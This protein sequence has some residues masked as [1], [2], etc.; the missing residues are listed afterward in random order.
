MLIIIAGATLFLTGIIVFLL[1]QF[2]SQF[3]YTWLVSV[4]ASFIAWALVLASRWLPSKSI[5]LE[6]WLP[7]SLL[8][9]TI[10]FVVD[11]ISWPYAFSLATILFAVLL[12][13]AVENLPREGSKSW[14]G[15][16]LVTGIGLLVML[17]GNPLTLVL[18]WAA[19][20]VVEFTVIVRSITGKEVLNRTILSFTSRLLGV[21]LATWSMLVS[22]TGP[23]VLTFNDITPE[24]GVFMLLASGLRLGVIPL[25]LPYVKE[26][27]L[28][29]GF[30][31][32]LRLLAPASSLVVLARLPA[33]VVQP[34]VA[35]YLL[36]LTA[37]ASLYGSFMWFTSQN[38]LDARPYWLVALAGMSVAS[39]IRGRP[40]ASVAW[41]LALILV[42]GLVF[43]YYSRRKEISMVVPALA[44]LGLSGLPY[45]PSASGWEGLIVLPF[46]ALDVIYLITHAL[47]LMGTIRLLTKP[48]IS[49]KGTERWLQIVYLLGLLVLVVSH[50]MIGIF[51]WKG[52]L[53]P[54]TWWAPTLSIVITGGFFIFFLQKKTS[55]KLQEAL[56][57]LSW[58]NYIWSLIGQRFATFFSLE[59]FY[60]FM[61]RV[62]IILQ[63]IQVNFTALLE[64]QGGILWT[65]L[66]LVLI[67][68]I[69]GEW[70]LR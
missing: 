54:G 28:R 1:I 35:V 53:T 16:M 59:W 60:R 25:H 45:S 70:S 69:L 37:S 48:G 14:S 5:V 56:R 55:G 30:G 62:F 19:I 29:R 34:T 41:G 52:S 58:I 67:V 68:T 38:E 18:A 57:R 7:F 12:T 61:Y 17:V 13:T 36:L 21:F 66:F 46:S 33:T 42:G 63:I 44:V 8:G 39:V 65:I 6:G 23:N 11:S 31:T 51:G 3:H 50:W 26:L 47:I 64:G 22:Q 27:R 32:M 15:S 24:V 10:T 40:E 43:Q 9:S 4:G 20:D 2:R 49:L